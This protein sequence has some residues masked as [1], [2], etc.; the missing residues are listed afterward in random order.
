MVAFPLCFPGASVPIAMD[1]S[2]ITALDMVPEGIV[3]G[4]TSGKKVHVFVAMFHGVT[5]IVFDMQTLDSFE[6]SAAVCCGRDGLV[7]LANDGKSGSVVRGKFQPLPFDCIQEWGFERTPF[8][9]PVEIRSGEK[10]IHATVDAAKETVVGT[11]EG[12]L[13]TYSFAS[14]K[15][16]IRGEIAGR[17]RVVLCPSGKFVYGLDNK[18]SLWAF[19][20]KKQKVAR[21]KIPLPKGNWYD[22]PM[23]WA[24]D[25]ANGMLY[26]A[27]G[28]GRLFSFRSDKGF[29]RA[30]GKTLYFPVT[31]MAATF[32][33]RVFGTCGEGM[34]D[35]F[36]YSP[37]EKKISRIGLAVSTLERRRYGYRFGD[38]VVGRDG[39]I[40]FGENDNL[41]HLWI[42]FPRIVG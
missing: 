7:V 22:H 20:L 37:K 36:C 17:G 16:S 27:D 41:G 19:D 26:V 15:L 38:A 34:E 3:Y 30:L 14:R 28:D 18:N 24:R 10:A 40:Y 35:L 33:G 11:T 32:D 13:F 6:H 12:H 29:S 2:R 23:V 42:Y 31:T 8:E 1:E 39:Q 25:T 21:N 5:G 9:D 4:A